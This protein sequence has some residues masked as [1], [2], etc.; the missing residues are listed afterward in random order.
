MG[1]VVLVHKF[2]CGA[3]SSSNNIF[4]RSFLSPLAA[5]VFFFSQKQNLR[6]LTTAKGALTTSNPRARFF[7]ARSTPKRGPKHRRE[8][9][10][11]KRSCTDQR[12]E[13]KRMLVKSPRKE[14]NNATTDVRSPPLARGALIQVPSHFRRV[15][16]LNQQVWLNTSTTAKIT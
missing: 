2:L 1:T 13:R 12:R 16:Q 14:I 3:N 10:T 4:L 15:T 6:L 11:L 8:K 9:S 5:A 7:R